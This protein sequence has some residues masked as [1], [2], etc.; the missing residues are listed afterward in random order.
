M[1]NVQIQIEGNKA[2]ITID[3]TQ[4]FGMSQSGKTIIVASTE[5]NKQIPGTEIRLGLN[6]Y[7]Y[8]PRS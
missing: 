5:G 6:A 4:T 1:K 8:P 2:I 7:K 3:L